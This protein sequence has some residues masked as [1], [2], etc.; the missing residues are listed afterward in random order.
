MLQASRIYAHRILYDWFTGS[1]HIE[2]LLHFEDSGLEA[3]DRRF[4][5][6]LI[7]HV[8]MHRRM[9]EHIVSRFY[10]KKPKKAILIV[11]LIGACEIL[12][13][14]VRDHAAV[15]TA[16]ELAAHI[17]RRS[18]DFVNAVLRKVLVFR[19]AEWPAL[20]KDPR[21]PPGIRYD[22]PDWLIRRWSQQFGSETPELLA[23]LNER[24]EKTARIVRT[25]A[26]DRIIQALR[27]MQ[28]FAGVSDYHPDYVFI[29]S[30]QKLLQHALFREGYLTAQDVSAV[31]PVRLI[32]EDAPG[33]VADICCA[34]GGKLGA[35]RQY[36][37]P[38][39]PVHGYDRS[40]MRIAETRKNLAR[41][42]MGEIPLQRAD[43]AKDDYPG[44]SHILADVPCSGFG[45]IRKRPDLRWRRKEEDMPQLLALQRD[46]L[47]NISKDVKPGGLLVYSTCTFDKEENMGNI[48]RFLQRHPSFRIRPA[49]PALF[50]RE[51]ITPEGAVASYPHRHFCE[52]SFAIAL[53]KH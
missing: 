7:H 17:D 14:Q 35:L 19:E 23:S 27:E 33:S 43:A 30:W 53:Q 6:S 2:H 46:I 32:A 3:Q 22:F 34:P 29:R 37:P 9:L 10:R 20:Q 24:P 16:V 40:E 15:H 51:L 5:E 48:R 39:T 41:A 52:G 50:P 21:V 25:E 45:V 44:Y 36:C 4:A 11:L 1:E 31:F 28:V 38:E 26:R 13:M 42:G 49:D 8:I 47:D 12:Y 18:K